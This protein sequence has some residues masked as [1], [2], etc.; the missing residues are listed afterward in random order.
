MP[1]LRVPCRPIVAS[2]PRAGGETALSPRRERALQAPARKRVGA[3]R[4]GVGESEPV[5]RA[6]RLRLLLGRGELGSD[7][8]VPRWFRRPTSTLV[9]TSS[10]CTRLNCWNTIAQRPR[11]S[12]SRRPRRAVT[13]TPSNRILPSLGSTSRLIIRKSVDVPAPERPITPSIWPFGIARVDGVDGRDGA[14]PSR[15]SMEFEHSPPVASPA[16]VADSRSGAIDA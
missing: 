3:L 13:S 14:E 7:D 2:T 4:G 10:R 9:S 11:Q 15:D 8:S 16:T 1:S 6:D 12:Q 5:M